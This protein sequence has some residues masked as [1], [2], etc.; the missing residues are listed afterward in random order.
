MPAAATSAS[1]A[2]SWIASGVVRLLDLFTPSA[3][4]PRVPSEPAASP[5]P[6]QICRVKPT[7]EVLPLVPVTA[8]MHRG[9]RSNR[10][11][12]MSASRRRGLASRMSGTGSA[13]P[14]SEGSPRIATAPR[15]RASSMN[16]RPSALLPG[17][18]ANRVRGRTVRESA[19]SAAISTSCQPAPRTVSPGS[20]SRDSRI[21]ALHW[22]DTPSSPQAPPPNAAPSG[23][24][25]RSALR[26]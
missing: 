12:A 22:Q 6:L 7:T 11:A 2:C 3:S 10:R 24:S 20:S 26:P 8:V 19:L 4:S 5:R 16:V 21:R 23:R 1:R 25:G 9:W 18:A 14:A 13:R 17:N 15:A